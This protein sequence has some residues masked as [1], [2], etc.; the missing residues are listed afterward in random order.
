M[1]NVA[2]FGLTLLA[3]MV[4]ASSTPAGAAT[5]TVRYGPFTIPGATMDSMGNMM[6]GMIQNRLDLWVSK[7]CINCY[8]TK[9]APNL[10]YADGSNAN[11]NTGPMLHHV[12]WSSAFRSDP[13]CSGNLLGLIGE[14][15]FASG[16]ERTVMSLPSGYAYYVGLL[17]QWNMITDLMNHDMEAKTVYVTLTFTYQTSSLKRVRPVWLD[18]DQC[19]DSEFSIPAGVSDS[20]RDWTVNVEGKVVAIGGHLHDYGVRIEARNETLN[21]S[22]CNS[23]AGYNNKPEY[24]GSIDTMSVCIADPVAYVKNGQRVRIH[25]IYDSPQ[26]FSDRMGIMIGYIYPQA[27]P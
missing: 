4:I 24:M 22:I 18:I 3:A 7:P 11:L 5:K 23:V 2:R 19:G 21:T 9:M 27:V 1:R 15:F 13:T 25:A 14:R 10:V 17:D 6:P 12:V 20:H 16:N 8:I 26:T